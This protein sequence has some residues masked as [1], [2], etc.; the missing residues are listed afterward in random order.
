MWEYCSVVFDESDCTRFLQGDRG[1]DDESVENEESELPEVDETGNGEEILLP[2][3][4][5]MMIAG[6]NGGE[7]NNVVPKK[8]LPSVSSQ[9][10][11]YFF[12]IFGFFHNKFWGPFTLRRG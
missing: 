7:T 10:L 5:E 1:S 11:I 2:A 9:L 4:T 12:K 8:M 6:G 3:E